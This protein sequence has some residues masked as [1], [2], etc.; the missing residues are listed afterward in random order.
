[1]LKYARGLGG[2]DLAADDAP[3]LEEE[4]AQAVAEL[5][6]AAEARGV[7]VAGGVFHGGFD[8][9]ALAHACLAGGAV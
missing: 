7:R 1:M 2:L 8:G 5:A 3:P 9:L 4:L 6:R